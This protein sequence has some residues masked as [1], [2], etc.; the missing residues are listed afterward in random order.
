MTRKDY[1]LIAQTIKEARPALSPGHTDRDG[2][3]AAHEE[4]VLDRLSLMMATR[5]RTT[6]DAFNRGRFLEACGWQ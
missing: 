6:N 4:Q 2:T 1:V 5:L 3:F